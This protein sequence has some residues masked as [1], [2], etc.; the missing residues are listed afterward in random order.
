[1]VDSEDKI[2]YYNT[3]T[4]EMID[5]NLNLC[6][7]ILNEFKSINSNTNNFKWNL[8]KMQNISRKNTILFLI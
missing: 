5:M 7:F 3:I 4:D 2:Y 6:D 8:F 1:L